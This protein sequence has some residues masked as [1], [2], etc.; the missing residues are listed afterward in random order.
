M[1]SKELHAQ[2][3]SIL[4]TTYQRNNFI[5]LYLDFLNIF[6]FAGE[7]IIGNASKKKDYLNLQKQ[8][9]EKNYIKFQITHLHI[10]K[11][12]E[13]VSYSMN[14]CFIACLKKVKTDYVFLTCD[15]DLVFPSSL[16]KLEQILDKSNK[17]NGATGDVCWVG[18]NIISVHRQSNS[19]LS[20][21]PIDRLNEYIKKPFHSMFTLVRKEVLDNF[22][23]KDFKN[24]KFNHFAADYSWMLTIIINGPI[25]KINQ[26]VV[27]RQWHKSQLNRQKPFIEY[28]E[29]LNKNFYFEDKRKF[30]NHIN[31]LVN[32][33]YFKD[34]NQIEVDKFFEKYEYFRLNSNKVNFL[35]KTL[36]KIIS[37]FNT[38][39]K[40]DFNLHFLKEFAF[41]YKSPLNTSKVNVY[42]LTAKKIQYLQNKFQI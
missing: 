30:V 41:G 37:M 19:I 26:P 35:D 7:V 10:P 12:E 5:N 38:L 34:S 23:P 25:K 18:N 31:S 9:I 14:D 8:I 42:N 6:N 22:V 29:F 24:I 21:E 1:K 39:F 33:L 4:I 40:K 3:V 28:S 20:Q 15:D 17:Y 11:I 32:E 27:F 2:N 13:N 36:S 16:S